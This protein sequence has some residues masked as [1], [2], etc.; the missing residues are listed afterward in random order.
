MPSQHARQTHEEAL[1]AVY[2]DSLDRRNGFVRV[3]TSLFV[4]KVDVNMPALPE[5]DFFV[6]TGATGKFDILRH[7]DQPYSSLAL[8]VHEFIWLKEP[9]LPQIRKYADILGVRTPEAVESR[10]EA[11]RK[12]SMTVMDDLFKN[13]SPENIERSKK[14]V[15]SF[16]HVLMK[17]P[18]AYL[19]LTKL[20]S[21]DP[22]TLQHSVGTSVNTIILGRKLGI[23]NETDLL[24]LGLAGL[25]HDIGKVKV[26]TEIINKPGPL[27]DEEWEE[28]K[29]HAEEGFHIVKDN[30]ML[31]V[32]TK[33]AILEHHEER[34]GTGYPG[35]KTFSE[36]DVYSKIVCIC[37]I[38][39][40]LT[41]NRSYSKAKTPFEAFQLIQSKMAH[42]V[43]DEIFKPL[44]MIY[45]G[46][47]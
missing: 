7:G 37:D 18:Q 39:N 26:K 23:H 13:P 34:D 5:V 30:P 4:S 43:D 31:A 41:T 12:S 8:S 20:S 47:F 28:M 14:L 42:K 29:Q 32:R 3:P 40:A 11:L 36:I 2:S 22:Y 15:S 21:H 35:H 19:L 17:E 38:F 33:R 1:Q 27:N 45:G 10:I 44:V 9:E 25:L 16:V 24:E 46:K 6:E